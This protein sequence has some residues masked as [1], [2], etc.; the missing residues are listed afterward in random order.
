M[1]SLQYVSVLIVISGIPTLFIS[2]FLL[3]ESWRGSDTFPIIGFDFYLL[4]SILNIPNQAGRLIA[5][6]GVV[7]LFGLFK[8]K[9]RVHWMP[10]LILVPGLYLTGS[11]AAIL[12]FAVGSLILLQYNLFDDVRIKKLTTIAIVLILFFVFAFAFFQTFQA[13][14]HFGM[15]FS[16]HSKISQYLDM[17]LVTPVNI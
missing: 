3:F 17:G 14:E 6:A 5:L 7:S 11:R 1:L 13:D 9:S 10:L 12:S 15:E 16:K 2:D 4:R 8:G